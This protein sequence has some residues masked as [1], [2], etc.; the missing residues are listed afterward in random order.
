VSAYGLLVLLALVALI[1]LVFRLQ[2][3]NAPPG[4]V[5]IVTPTAGTPLTGR[6]EVRVAPVRGTPRS[7]ALF[8]DGARLA[9]LREAPYRITVDAARFEPAEL[10]D[11]DHTLSVEARFD[12]GDI[13]QDSV[14]VYVERG[15][16]EQVPP[17]SPAIRANRPPVQSAGTVIWGSDFEDGNLAVYGDVRTEGSGRAGSHRISGRARTG[18]RALQVTVPPSTAGGDVGRYQ[19][20]A[21]LAPERAGQER[22][23]GFSLL[24]GEEWDLSQIGVNRE[25][26]LLL[27]NDRYTRDDDNGPGGTNIAGEMQE[28][29]VFLSDTNNGSGTVEESVIDVGPMFTSRW[30]D[31]VIH[32]RW[33]MGADGFR[34]IWR[35][36]VPMG[37][38]EGPTVYRDSPFEHRIGIYEG[39]AV[40]HRRSLYVDNHRIGTS[41]AAVDPSQ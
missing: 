5:R 30:I 25:H 26:F 11:G 31:F 35:N 27:V 8:L 39:A 12:G 32:V 4:A 36:G 9:V 24:L 37:R 15:L 16:R 23:Y 3:E 7:V 14:T 22:W 40:D 13:A 17:A 20:V 29:P 34:E 21:G 10:S 28:R 1:A 33:S 2:D 41:Y 19:L 6:V 18:D 38:W